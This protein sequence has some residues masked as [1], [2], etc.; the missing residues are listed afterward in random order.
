VVVLGSS[1]IAVGVHSAGFTA[2]ELRLSTPEPDEPHGNRHTE[3][4]DADGA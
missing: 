2:L 1:L 3:H 4:R